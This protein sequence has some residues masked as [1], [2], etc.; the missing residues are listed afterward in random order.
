[1]TKRKKTPWQQKK[2]PCGFPLPRFPFEHTLIIEKAGS[3]EP[4]RPIKTIQTMVSEVFWAIGL[5]SSPW[6]SLFW[7]T[8]C[9]SCKC[10]TPPTGVKFHQVTPDL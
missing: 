4:S 6:G 7:G 1:M 3:C 2:N 5:H 10:I 9:G 8:K